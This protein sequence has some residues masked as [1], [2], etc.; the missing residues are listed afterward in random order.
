MLRLQHILFCRELGLPLAEI[1]RIL[2][3]PD[4]DTRTAL[5]DLR[6]RVDDEIA[7]RRDGADNRPDVGVARR[8][9]GGGRSPP[10]LRCVGREAGCVGGGDRCPLRRCRDVAMRNAKA[11]MESLSPAQLLD[12]KAEIDAIHADIAALI[13]A[14]TPSSAAA[15]GSI[16]R[17]YRWVCRSWLPDARAYAS[18]GRMYDD[19]EDFYE[20][21]RPPRHHDRRSHMHNRE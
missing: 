6:R 15:Q 18:L 20:P 21:P 2:D 1:A 11:G 17:H 3:D 16:A 14:G 7:Q 4:F 9:Q 19:H 13:E 8:R 10:L 5:L 12:F